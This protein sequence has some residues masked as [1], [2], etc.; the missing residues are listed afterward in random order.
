MTSTVIETRSG[1]RMLV[2][3]MSDP[4]VETSLYKHGTYEEGTLDVL[5][6]F[7]HEGDVFIDAGANIGV[8]SLTA[9]LL[10]GSKGS[11]FAFEPAKETFEI[12][13]KNIGL[14]ARMNIRAFRVALGA[15]IGEAMMYKPN[16]SQASMIKQSPEYKEDHVATV[17]TLDQC[18]AKEG[19]SKVRMVK[20]DVEGW[21][22]E[23]MQGAKKL[24]S[25]EDLP[26]L[27]VEFVRHRSRQSGNTFDIYTHLLSLGSYRIFLL[28]EGK[29]VPSPFV[30]VLSAED[31]PVHDNLFCFPKTMLEAVD[32]GIMTRNVSEP[33]N[34]EMGNREEG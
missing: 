25:A 10:V 9:S 19:L 23:V 11:V 13:K 20:I 2:D 24:L 12:L 1:L 27:I 6:Q 3:P 28:K 22:L 7:L 29:K 18:I 34:I 17:Q 33:S 26:I 15:N 16:R 4:W 14:N 8:M 31:L 30:E 5:K 32:N 21:E